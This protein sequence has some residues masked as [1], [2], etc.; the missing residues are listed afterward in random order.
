MQYQKIM[1]LFQPI[2]AGAFMSISDYLL[3]SSNIFPFYRD[4]FK[5]YQILFSTLT[6]SYIG[7]TSAFLPG[8]LLSGSH[9]IV[10]LQLFLFVHYYVCQE[11]SLL[12]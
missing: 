4:A 10:L 12:A 2:L 1:L 11:K 8:F 9:T 6:Y 7:N 5:Y 3:F